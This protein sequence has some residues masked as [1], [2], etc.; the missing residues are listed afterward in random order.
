ME[1]LQGLTLATVAR[2]ILG[3]TMF[4]IGGDTLR[5]LRA[6]GFNDWAERGGGAIGYMSR[7]YGFGPEWYAIACI[8]CAAVVFVWRKGWPSI[9]LYLASMPIILYAGHSIIPLLRSE[10]IANAPAIMYIGFYFLILAVLFYGREIKL[11]N[12]D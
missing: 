6:V 9:V 1:R 10:S 8:F 7:V 3:I 4:S 2:V 5:H 12:D 11:F